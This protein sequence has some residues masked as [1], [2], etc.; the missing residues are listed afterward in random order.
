MK[1]RV[2][3]SQ[4]ARADLS[5]IEDYIAERSGEQ[6]AEGFVGAIRDTCLSLETFPQRGRTTRGGFRVIG[7]RRRANILFQITGDEVTIIGVHYGGRNIE[8]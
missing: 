2:I 5:E 3:F 7:H 1:F 4:D 8:T 6:R